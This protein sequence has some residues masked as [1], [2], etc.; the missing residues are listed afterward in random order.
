LNLLAAAAG[1]LM[2][3]GTVV[4]PSS[5]QLADIANRVL[6][7]YQQHGKI[8]RTDSR[9]RTADRPAEHLIVALLGAPGFVEAAFAR[10][11]LVDG[12]GTVAVYSHRVYG[13]HAGGSM[14][15][16]LKAKGPGIERTLMSWDRMPSAAALKSLPQSR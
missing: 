10:V 1:V 15:E 5:E 3:A 7:N 4:G 16:W 13:R 9:P 11:V 12:V 2:L 8:V 14:G 6:G